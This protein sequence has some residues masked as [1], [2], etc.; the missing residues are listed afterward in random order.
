[1]EYN[2]WFSKDKEGPQIGEYSTVHAESPEEAAEKFVSANEESYQYVNLTWKGRLSTKQTTIET[3]S[4]IKRREEE[5][6]KEFQQWLLDCSQRAELLKKTSFLKLHPVEKIKLYNIVTLISS[7][8]EERSLENEE[9]EFLNAWHELKDRELGESLLSKHEM[10]K[11]KKKQGR[12]ELAAAFA[13]QGMLAQN[14]L[15]DIADDVG[16]ISDGGGGFD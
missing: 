8:L 10:S 12:S 15:N 3:V 16:D 9:I 6:R 5:E 2:C 7:Q 11:P 13:M 4:W 1:M 14:T